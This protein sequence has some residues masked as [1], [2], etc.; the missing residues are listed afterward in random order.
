MHFSFITFIKLLGPN[1]D[2]ILFTFLLIFFCNSSLSQKWKTMGLSGYGL[3]PVSF[4]H[5]KSTTVN[6]P[7]C[8]NNKL[9]KYLHAVEA[10]HRYTQAVSQ[11]KDASSIGSHFFSS[12]LSS[13]PLFSSLFS[14]FLSTDPKTFSGT[15]G[16]IVC[17]FFHPWSFQ[18]IPF[19]DFVNPPPTYLLETSTSFVD[20]K[21]SK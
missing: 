18:P 2:L 9:I 15:N 10:V 3:F 5:S 12:L 19:I 6:L 20:F 21:N 7:D 8:H 17:Y 13:F 1:Q 11:K 14:F 4:F 16:P